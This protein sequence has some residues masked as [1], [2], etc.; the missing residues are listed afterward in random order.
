MMMTIKQSNA[1]GVANKTEAQ[2][3][4]VLDMRM[5]IKRSQTRL[6]RGQDSG[7][8]DGRIAGAAGDSR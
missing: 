6:R 2:R 5:V 8:T 7:T 4:R 3:T 1:D